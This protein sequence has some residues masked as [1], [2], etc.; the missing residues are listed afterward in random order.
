MILPLL[1]TFC[2]Q[3]NIFAISEAGLD[4]F[5]VNSFPNCWKSDPNIYGFCLQRGM[6]YG[7]FFPVNQLRGQKNLWD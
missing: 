2:L 1:A 6:G 7:V 4:K 3:S 5:G